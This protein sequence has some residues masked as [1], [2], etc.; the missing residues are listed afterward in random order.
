LQLPGNPYGSSHFFPAP[1]AANIAYRTALYSACCS[2]GKL[3]LIGSE[4]E[5]RVFTF[6][7]A[8]ETLIGMSSTKAIRYETD[9]Q[10]VRPTQVPRLI[11]DTSKFRKATGWEPKL[12]FAKILSDTLNYWRWRVAQDVAP[13][14]MAS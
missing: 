6:R 7:Q 14:E 12:S 2:K 1:T 13:M 3:Y 5:D 11:A 8:L 9:A 4:G 10:Y